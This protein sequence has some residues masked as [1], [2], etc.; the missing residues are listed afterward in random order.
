LRIVVTNP[1]AD[2]EL[3]TLK[4]GTLALGEMV[5]MFH[6]ALVVVD[7]FTHQSAWILPTAQRI[8]GTFRAADVRVGFVVTG[9]P[10]EARDFLGPVAD[11]FLVL[12][13]PERKLVRSLGLESLPAWVHIDHLL[14]VE[15]SAQGWN[16]DE[17]RLAA[18]HL[19][20]RMDWTRPTIP[21]AGDP[22]P[23]HGSPAG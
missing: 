13:D 20:E 11:E 6:L 16:P 23:F 12:A 21:T 2:V 22:V 1:A 5:T 10:D 4:G 17:W 19:A 14:Q 15:A 18:E 7:P 3:Q 9:T 8:L